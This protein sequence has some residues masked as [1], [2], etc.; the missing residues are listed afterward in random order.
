[1]FQEITSFRWSGRTA[2]AGQAQNEQRAGHLFRLWPIIGLGENRNDGLVA[3]F[4]ARQAGAI[5]LIALAFL[6]APGW[7]PAPDV[8]SG[9][10]PGSQVE[11]LV[12]EEW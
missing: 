10:R 9:R 12:V 1:M 11:C 5:S 4:S 8:K 7:E 2:E 6:F 3:A